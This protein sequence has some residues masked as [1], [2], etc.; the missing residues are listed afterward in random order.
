[1][2]FTLRSGFVKHTLDRKVIFKLTHEWDLL[3][4]GFVYLYSLLPHITCC[5]ALLTGNCTWDFFAKWANSSKEFCQGTA[6]FS[7]LCTTLALPGDSRFVRISDV[8]HQ[9]CDFCL[10]EV[11]PWKKINHCLTI[12]WTELEYLSESWVRPKR[13]GFPWTS[14]LA[15][16]IFVKQPRLRIL[17]F[18]S[19]FLVLP[20]FSW[21][22]NTI[23]DGGS[24]AL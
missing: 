15:I 19:A 17:G 5:C 14:E 7:V 18:G 9:F 20:L 1:M 10:S 22:K 11:R 8:H 16:Y 21:E 2:F 13:M 3:R 23:G 12:S 4:A 6:L 24:T